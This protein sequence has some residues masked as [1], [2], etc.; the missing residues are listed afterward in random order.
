ML[1]VLSGERSRRQDLVCERDEEDSERGRGELEGVAPSGPGDA[2]RRQAARNLSDDGDAVGFEV[3]RPRDRDRGGDDEESRRHAWP[4]EPERQEESKRGRA[5]GEGR[6]ADV[7]ELARHLH[8][9]P[10]H[11]ACLHVQAEDCIDLRD[12]EHD[13]DAVDVAEKHRA[14]EV[15]RDPV[16]PERPGDE[17]ARPD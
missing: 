9:L 17:K 10:R 15:V 4:L 12:H 2:E 6:T 11:A 1:A 5:N 8:E 7:A 3:D 13:G 14:R 16:Q